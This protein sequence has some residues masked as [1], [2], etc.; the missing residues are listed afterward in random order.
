MAMKYCEQH[1]IWY[2]YKE[3]CPECGKFGRI[4]GSIIGNI[5]GGGIWATVTAARKV[6]E[7]NRQQKEKEATRISAT[8][9]KV[10]DEHNVVFNGSSGINIHVKFEVNN[11]MNLTGNCCA[12]FYDRDKKPLMDNNRNYCAANGQVSVGCTYTPGYK[13]CSY[14]DFVLF[15]PYSELHLTAGRH[16]LKFLI[17]IFDYNMTNIASSGFSD[18]WVNWQE[19]QKTQTIP[20][21]VQE[22]RNYP[23]IK[24]IIQKVINYYPDGSAIV[25]I[26]DLYVQFYASDETTLTVEAASDNVV[27]RIGKRDKAFN[28]L[29]FTIDRRIDNNYH[30][31]YAT[32][33]LSLIINDIKQIF[34]TIYKVRFSDYKI[35]DNC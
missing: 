1:N 15:I 35:D 8:I 28:K 3:G 21:R 4:A 33:D 6:K 19:E 20:Q 11:M 25:S 14:D 27:P 12:Y 34:E 13:K 17:Q 7:Y 31:K 24:S 23:D 16:D 10:W 26:G 30:R 22:R 9:N 29:G 2:D 18:F 32:D 5:I